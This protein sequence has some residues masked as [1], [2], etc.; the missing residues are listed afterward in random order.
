[1]SEKLTFVKTRCCYCSSEYVSME[2]YEENFDTFKAATSASWIGL[3]DSERSEIWGLI[4][5]TSNDEFDACVYA[6][7]I[8]ARLKE[9]NI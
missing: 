9:I 6:A 4:P 2:Q 7:A 3:D 8:E 1:M 5:Q